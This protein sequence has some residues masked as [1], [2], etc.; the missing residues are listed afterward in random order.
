MSKRNFV[1]RLYMTEQTLPF[2]EERYYDGSIGETWNVAVLQLFDVW[3]DEPHDVIREFAHGS[4]REA[5]DW[6]EGYALENG[7]RYEDET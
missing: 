4:L 7:Y 6:S 3:T 5:R 2:Q 1:L